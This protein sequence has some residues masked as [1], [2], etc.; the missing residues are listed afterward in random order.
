VT[1]RPLRVFLSRPAQMR[2]QGMGMLELLK[3]Q[4]ARLGEIEFVE[5]PRSDYPTFGALAEV[6][7]LVS[8][9]A[10]M[11]V[12]GLGELEIAQGTWR[13]GTSDERALQGAMWPS[14]WAQIE[15]GIAIGLDLPV[16]LLAAQPLDTGVFAADA[17]GHFIFRLNNA[18]DLASGAAQRLLDDWYATA[19]ERATR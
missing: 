15:A 8:G 11:V 3:Q 18:A 9:C 2:A 14:P 16:L 6:R 12:L 19:H 1:S 7:K 13:A 4:L 17:D 5:L 10:G